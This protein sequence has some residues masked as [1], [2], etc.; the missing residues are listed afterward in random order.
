MFVHGYLTSYADGIE[1]GNRLWSFLRAA[2]DKAREHSL[3]S[4]PFQSASFFTFCWRGDF[5]A[6]NFWISERAARESAPSFAAFLQELH[7]QAVRR[8]KP[9]K[10]VVITHSLGA[11]VALEAFKLLLPKE[12]SEWVSC[13]FLVQPAIPFGSV[14]R[15]VYKAQYVRVAPIWHF[16]KPSITVSLPL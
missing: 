4:D 7:S 2:A 6:P 10:L 9:L 11:K 5:G 1:D 13:T 14:V 8:N 16:R 15:E 12:N 3:P